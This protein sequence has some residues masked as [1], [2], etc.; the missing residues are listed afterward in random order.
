MKKILIISMQQIKIDLLKNC[1]YGKFL[2]I[3]SNNLRVHFDTLN[4]C[5][6]NSVVVVF[7]YRCH[8]KILPDIKKN[9]IFYA[10][11]QITII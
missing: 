7:H 9:L 8:C 3:L 4:R 10:A 5:R 1:T 2:M 6:Q 11:K